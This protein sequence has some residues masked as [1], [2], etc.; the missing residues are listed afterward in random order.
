MVARRALIIG[1]S[2][3]GLFAGLLLQRAGLAA[4]VYERAETELTGRGAGIVTQPPIRGV[5]R[6]AGCDATQDLGVEVASRRT[7]DRVGRVLGEHPCPQTLT[8]WDGVFRILRDKFPAGHYHLGRELVRIDEHSD[9]VTAH[10]ADGSSASGD[11][12]VGADGFR[13][14]VRG[15]ALPEVRPVY[16]GYVG[17]RGL[18]DEAALSSRTHAE[19]FDA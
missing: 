10:F 18:A 11:L 3:S 13:S 14:T 19:I 9:G 6:A 12:I 2:M 4:E 5:L 8:S 7:L 15:A 17:W 1:G 16:A